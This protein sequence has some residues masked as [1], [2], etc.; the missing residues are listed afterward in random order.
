MSERTPGK[1]YDVT[2]ISEV[3]RC[4]EVW[5]REFTV[6]LEEEVPWHRHSEVRDRCYCLEGLLRVQ[7]V[8]ADDDVEFLLLAPGESC[9][10]P[11]GTAHRLTCARGVR[12]RYL[13][14][15]TGSYDFVKVQAPE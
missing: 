1:N 14:V 12:A 15:Q 10:L 9:D 6:Q 7:F 8:N 3:A 4:G 13:L 11:A 2:N 5:V